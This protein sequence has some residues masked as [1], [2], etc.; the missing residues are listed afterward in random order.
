[1]KDIL[2]GLNEKQREAVLHFGH[3]LLILAG[4]GS[5]K[6]RVITT[7]IAYLI[8]E[9]NFEPSSILGVTFTNKAADEMRT[10]IAGMIRR[11]PPMIKTFH[12]F[13][14][15]LLRRNSHL[16]G[17]NS[18]FLIYDEND[19]VRILK[20][21]FGKQYSAEELKAFMHQISRLKDSCIDPDGDVGKVSFNPDLRRVYESYQKRLKDTGNLDFGDLIMLSVRLLSD[22]EAVRKRIRQRFRAILVD[23]YQDSNHAQFELLKE[24]YSG[25]NYL[26]VVGDEDQ[27][28]YRF[29]GA[30]IDNILSFPRH[31][32]GTDIIRLERNYRSTMPILKVASAVVS[33]N[34]NRLGKNLW[35]DKESGIPVKLVFLNDQQHEAEFCCELLEDGN[36]GGTAILYRMNAQSRIFEEYFTNSGIPYRVIGTKRFYERE[37]VKDAIAYLALALNPRDSVSFHRIV[38]KPARGIG[39][40][41]LSRVLTRGD[42]ERDILP[43]IR[44]NLTD[45]GSGIGTR[46]RRGIED[47]LGIIDAVRDR[48]NHHS[49]SDTIRFIIEESGLYRYYREKDSSMGSQKADNLEELVNACS[50]YGSGV[51][52]ALRFLENISLDSSEENPYIEE[53]AVSLITLHNTKGLEFERVIITGL[54]QSII[55]HHS[56]SE[57]DDEVEE[58][59][60]LFYVGITRAKKTLVL[61]SCRRRRIFGKTQVQ[62]PSRFLKEIPEKYIEVE[63]RSSAGDDEYYPAGS[64]VYHYE[65]GSGIILKNW[66]NNGILNVVVRFENGKIAR[67]IPKYAGLK[68]IEYYD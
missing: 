25:D 13:G 61:T 50:T 8:E 34:M 63:D 37:E 22:H 26:C 58:E 49:L 66:Y 24:L 35:T 18:S 48:L 33:N 55:P 11:E 57:S 56:N 54:E 29:R 59:R 39:K 4:A 10:R 45:R 67:L 32:P 27:S 36:Y 31:F 38:N 42:G 5:G 53:N 16:L 44:K 1:M 30:D 14:A 68:R 41:T 60:R 12:S 64:L 40:V 47:F 28:I 46:A 65:Y 3:P 9:R 6:T 15:W 17:L 21:L 7:K 2:E 43:C 52:E 62:E 23:E 19:S 20:E 51:D